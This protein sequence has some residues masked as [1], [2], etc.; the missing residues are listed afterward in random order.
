MPIDVTNSP[1]NTNAKEHVHSIWSGHIANARICI[2][3]LD[4]SHFARKR[5]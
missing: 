4:G 5:I 3:I 2:F 1:R